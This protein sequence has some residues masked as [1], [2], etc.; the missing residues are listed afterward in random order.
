MVENVE[1][2]RKLTSAVC[3][4]VV[5]IVEFVETE[6]KP[7]DRISTVSTDLHTKQA[8][9]VGESKNARGVKNVFRVL[10]LPV[11]FVEIVETAHQ[12]QLW[13]FRCKRSDLT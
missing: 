1:T 8:Q 4:S 11:E 6:G 3:D 9:P 12:P 2:A 10:K 7:A 5:E 13:F